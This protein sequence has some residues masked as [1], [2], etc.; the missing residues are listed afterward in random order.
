[1]K[2]KNSPNLF[3]AIL[4]R[5][6]K[7]KLSHYTPRRR[8]RESRYS[9]YSFS[10][11]ALD[12]GE[13]SA[14]RSGRALRPGKGHP[15]PIVQRAGWAAQPFWN[16]DRPV[17]QPVARHCTDWATWLTL[18][19]HT[20][21]NFGDNTCVRRYRHLNFACIVRGWCKEHKI[22]EALLQASYVTALDNAEKLKWRKAI[23]KSLV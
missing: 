15:V 1:V 3:F 7:L 5:H 17:D 10:T 4:H 8:L 20:H 2:I 12:M 23:G 14:S 9:S 18:H 21:N 16:L 13:W 22:K 6:K 19:R 11:S